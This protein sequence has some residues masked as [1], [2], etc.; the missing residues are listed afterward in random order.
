MTASD[1]TGNKSASRSSA[2]FATTHWSVVL[3]ARDSASPGSQE[4]LERLCRTYWYPLYAFV[5]RKGYSPEDAKDLT[6]AFFERFLEKHY[7]REVLAEKGRFR[8]FLLTS[9]THFLANEW[10]RLKAAKR[11]GDCQFI[12]LDPPTLEERYRTDASGEESPERHYDR[13][14]AEAVMDRA[15]AL[16]EQEHRAAGKDAQFGA[17]ADFLSRRPDEGEYTAVGDR[18]GL[19][20]HAVSVAVGRLRERYRALIQTEIEDTVEG[21]AEVDA[22]LGYL[23]ELVTQ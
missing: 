1:D 14:W 20:S 3:A 13:L 6:Q 11:G 12:P 5:R 17:L 15:L 18:L 10:D 7:L 16:L 22:E 4:A 9:L 8:T 21:S 23:I 19:N 2:Q